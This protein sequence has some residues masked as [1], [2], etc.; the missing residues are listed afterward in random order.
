MAKKKAA[1]NLGDKLVLASR[2][3]H[4]H[5]V[6]SLL[7]LGA[8]ANRTDSKGRTALYWILHNNANR[9]G[10][11]EAC[12]TRERCPC[13]HCAAR[14][15]TCLPIVQAIDAAKRLL[16]C[17]QGKDCGGCVS[18]DCT[19][20][21]VLAV[22]GNAVEV[23]MT[24]LDKIERMSR[25]D[26]EATYKNNTALEWAIKHNYE[27]IAFRL[28]R[29]GARVMQLTRHDKV[30]LYLRLSSMCMRRVIDEGQHVRVRNV[31]NSL[32]EHIFQSIR[33]PIGQ[34]GTT[35]IPMSGI[36]VSGLQAVHEREFRSGLDM[37]DEYSYG[38][39][40][41][42]FDES[43]YDDEELDDF[44]GLRSGSAHMGSSDDDDEGAIS[45][46]EMMSGAAYG[47]GGDMRRVFSEEEIRALRDAHF[48]VPDVH[49]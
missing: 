8:H 28:L 42:Y 29:L 32:P 40:D 22:A 25:F 12:V 10:E 5:H 13:P 48:E 14:Q 43:I 1:S 4:Y 23:V 6:S 7:N 21:L 16:E 9:S 39:E 19:S 3:G 24:M 45:D 33:D 17:K 18:N 44:I 2:C 38:D 15:C 46:E 35:P 20:E 47:R 37:S 27:D 49:F 36:D 41:S 34:R 31:E 30:P 11:C 26:F